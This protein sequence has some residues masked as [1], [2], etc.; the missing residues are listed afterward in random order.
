MWPPSF[1][2]AR[3][4][5]DQLERS[6]GLAPARITAVRSELAAAEKASGPARQTALKKLAT[7][8]NA[9]A[10]KSSD[11]PKV[12]MLDRGGAGAGGRQVTGNRGTGGT[13]ELDH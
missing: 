8:L 1:A 4:F 9:D 12:R 7:Q 3:A 11:Q 13:G 10:A 6:K 2:K 5:V